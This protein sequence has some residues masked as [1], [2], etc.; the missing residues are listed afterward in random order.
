M[1]NNKLEKGFKLKTN[2]CSV[3]N[4]SSKRGIFLSTVI[5]FSICV[6]LIPIEAYANEMDVKMI[7]LEETAIITVTNNSEKDIN[8]FRI[9]LG[10]NFDFESFKTEKGWI[11]EKT[12]QGVIIFTTSEPIKI[13]ESVKFGIKADKVNPII[14]WKAL[15]QVDEI[16]K[17]GVIE[18]NQLPDI[19]ENPE[20]ESSKNYQ[21]VGTSIFPDSTFRVIPEKPNSGSTIRVTGDQFG[22]LQEFNF[23]IDSQKI[24]EF[25]TDENGHFITTMEIPKLQ[26]E[27]RVNFKVVSYDGIEKKISLRL[28]ENENRIPQSENIKLSIEGI[29]NIVSRGEILEVFGTGT[30]GNAITVKIIDSEQTITNTRTAEVDSTG[31]WKLVEPITVPFDAIF[32]KYSTIVSDGRNQ[33]LKNWKV[34]TD[35]V[36]LLS[37]TQLMFDAGELIKFNGT[38]IPNIPV[39]IILEDSLGNEIIS[40]IVNTDETGYLEFE[41]QSVENDD[42]EGT[43]TLIVSQ[44]KNK[45]FV[46]VGYDEL[47]SI[48]VN[49]V[50]D[51]SNYQSTDTAIIS[52]VGK[53]SD[54]LSMIIITPSGSIQG[55]DRPIK[56]QA[57]GRAKYNLDLDGFVS[58]I[59]T[60]VIQKGNSQNSEQFA[61]GLQI[62]SGNIDAKTTQIEY[63]Q[64]ERILLLGNTN[65]N[66]LLIGTLVDPSGKIVKTVDIASD[67]KGVFTEERIRIPSNGIQGVWKINVASGANLD[68]IEFNVFASNEE[69]MSVKV[70]EKV[71]AGELIKISI[72]AS[73][74]TLVTIEIS[75]QSGEILDKSLTC[76]TTKEFICETFWPVPKNMP[77]GT[78]LLKVNDAISSD[79]TTFTVVP[80]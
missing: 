65:P 6:I 73:H 2:Y 43:W 26:K 68:T 58:G 33:V 51:K 27:N 63:Q 29:P 1:K 48:P 19:N 44:G 34:E 18:A 70:T 67:N 5:L 36:I 46:Y 62:G 77:Q 17:T 20:L 72:V 4:K 74:K 42:K 69:G 12:P 52:L 56:L 57:D 7:G 28:G 31:N 25:T 60:A 38:A 14:N 35:K 49:L 22:A 13:N 11:G 75:E 79:E 10:G 37:P 78:Y 53:P 30:P 47:P 15:D 41:Y 32:G 80:N 59:Y 64:G 39:E 76:N 24:G 50:F 61:V 3:M 71:K 45:E 9:W 8:M 40:D 21:N 23:Y 66:S 55:E 54:N 16:I